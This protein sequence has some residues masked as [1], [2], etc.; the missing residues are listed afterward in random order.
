LQKAEGNP[1]IVH[2]QPT[3][4]NQAPKVLIEVVMIQEPSPGRQAV[5]KIQLSRRL[6]LPLARAR[7]ASTGGIQKYEFTILIVSND[8]HADRIF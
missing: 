3:D 4:A 2:F 1:P 6:L 5:H 7:S 8:R